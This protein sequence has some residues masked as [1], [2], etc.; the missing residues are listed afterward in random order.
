MK[1]SFL[2]LWLEA[3]LQSWGGHSKFYRRDTVQFPT[4]SGILGMIL[5][6]MGA[7]G[8]QTY[9]LKNFSEL[10][11]T[12]YSYKHK[13]RI[14]E[15]IPILKDFQMVGAGY[16]QE[17]KWES[18]HIP[19]NNKGNKSVGG[20]AKLT[21]KYYLQ[22]A[23]FG[24]IVEIPSDLEYTIHKA[25][26]EPYY[27]IYLGRKNCIPTD[28][29]F[30]GIYV[31]HEQAEKKLQKIVEEKE[32]LREFTVLDGIHNGEIMYLGDVPIQFGLN[33]KYSTRE[34]TLIQD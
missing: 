12:V 25:L 17:D 14:N 7:T 20:G 11:Q 10:K 4:K 24:V 1:T 2:L 26:T 6:G 16:N 13:D 33:M 23:R 27:D 32:L 21:Y 8:K 3:P 30:R 28:L 18:M 29:V 5:C 15:Y 22:D 34:V 19:K 31:S 9:L